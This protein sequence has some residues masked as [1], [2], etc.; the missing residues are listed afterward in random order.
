[1]KFYFSSVIIAILIAG[2]VSAQHI[3]VGVKGG[4]NL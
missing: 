2:T 3:N 1:M 4:L